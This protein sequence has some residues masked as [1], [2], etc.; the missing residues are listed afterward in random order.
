MRCAGAY[1]F[2]RS[3]VQYVTPVSRGGNIYNVEPVPGTG[4]ILSAAFFVDS[5]LVGIALQRMGDA[6]VRAGIK[7]RSAL[8]TAVYRKTFA[9]SSIHNE[10][11]GNVVSL[12]S[13]DCSKLYEGVMAFHNVWTAPAETAAIIALL[14]GNIQQYGLPALG[15]VV[16]VLPL[17]YYFGLLIARCKTETVDVSDSRVLRMQVRGWPGLGVL[18]AP[19]P[20]AGHNLLSTCIKPA[21]STW[22]ACLVAAHRRF[23]WPSSW[24]SSTTGRRAL[25]SRL[26]T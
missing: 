8:M 21:C 12:V 14:L 13:T 25:P 17:Q 3:L 10:G 19:S 16:F 6:C 5:V 23:C 24:S 22:C 18:A 7:I 26:L 11:S 20:A 9:L 15:I 1:Y 2:V 4:W